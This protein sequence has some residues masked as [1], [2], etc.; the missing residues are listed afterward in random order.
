MVAK[1]SMGIYE[2]EVKV[3]SEKSGISV[4]LSHLMW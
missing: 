1:E 3:G 2:R 4:D